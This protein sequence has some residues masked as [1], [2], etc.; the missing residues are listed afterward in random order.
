MFGPIDGKDA[1]RVGIVITP[2]MIRSAKATEYTQLSSDASQTIGIT[3][4]STGLGKLKITDDG[5]EFGV[6]ITDILNKPLSE[7]RIDK[8]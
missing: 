4:H 7:W 1:A 5:S 6:P 3:H 8:K 2:Q